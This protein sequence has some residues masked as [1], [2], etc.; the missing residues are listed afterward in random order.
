MSRP[1]VLDGEKWKSRQLI[2]LPALAAVLF[3]LEGGTF[4]P[5]FASAKES[6]EPKASDWVQE[7]GANELKAQKEDHTQWRYCY[8]KEEP[9]R[10]EVREKIE[11]EDGTLDALLSVNGRALNADERRKEEARL[12]KKVMDGDEYRRKVKEDADE[13]TGLLKLLPEMLLCEYDGK[14]GDLI[15]LK[16]SPNP[17]FH[18]PSREAK[19]FHSME[20]TMLVDAKEK[21]LA[22][23]EGHLTG[24]VKFGGG[25][26]GRLEKGGTFTLNRSEV[27]AG[28]WEI[29]F[30]DIRMRGKVLLFKTISV[31]QQEYRTDFRRMPDDLSL[32]QAAQIL[33]KENSLMTQAQPWQR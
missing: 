7:V 12:Q 10:R 5:S 28:H 22:W 20:G 14:A 18:P 27:G 19:V 2:V 13:A 15:R 30:A 24:E 32:Q 6:N 8:R 4:I 33:G 29:T 23:I 3:L 16:F 1:S 26:L 21:R 11:T 31:Q 17:R 9:G 25:L